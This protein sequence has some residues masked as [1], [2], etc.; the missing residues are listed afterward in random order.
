[1][2]LLIASAP[3]PQ[4]MPSSG[5]IAPAGTS[6]LPEGAGDSLPSLGTTLL[7]DL[8]LAL[9]TQQPVEESDT[10]AGDP[11]QADIDMP[12]PV[13]RELPL[14]VI[15][16]T[17]VDVVTLVDRLL[18]RHPDAERITQQPGLAVV[19]PMPAPQSLAQL[20]MLAND[21]HVQMLLP[22]RPSAPP[23]AA[24]LFRDAMQGRQGGE[25]AELPSAAPTAR[26]PGADVLL[27]SLAHAAS[28]ATERAEAIVSKVNTM[29]DDNTQHK[30]LGALGERIHVQA[31]NGM[32]SAVIDLAP[33]MAG[34]VRIELRHE[35]GALQVRITASHAEVTQQLQ[36]ISEGLR[37][38]LNNRQFNDVAVQISHGR[39][40]DHGGR[41]GQPQQGQDGEAPS[42]QSPGRALAADASDEAFA[43]AWTRA[44]RSRGQHA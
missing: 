37:Q 5:D 27:T 6:P 35:A 21:E 30:L 22:T 15:T 8:D 13:L 11:V 7:F 31:K 36:A 1:M 9:A 24:G 34:K 4:S 26:A 39:H 44:N 12:A 33:Y 19:S 25:T 32:Q 18:G 23:V 17:D 2:N 40:A 28:P 10:D 16:D 42:Q 43:D 14:P 38:D 29:L 3:L 41:G 20:A